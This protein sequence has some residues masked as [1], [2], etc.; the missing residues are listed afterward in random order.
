MQQHDLAQQYLRERLF[1]CSGR[2]EPAQNR[3]QYNN[4]RR[5]D[6]L[7]L[8]KKVDDPEKRDDPNDDV[9]RVAPANDHSFHA[10]HVCFPL[11][12]AINFRGE[13]RP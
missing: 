6:P 11:F 12:S 9:L 3:A 1:F 2:G 10:S 7:V 5:P 13:S 8:S 4:G